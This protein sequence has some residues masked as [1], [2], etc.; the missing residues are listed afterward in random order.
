MTGENTTAILH[1]FDNG[2]YIECKDLDIGKFIPS[3]DGNA[4]ME[5][6][7]DIDDL[8]NPNTTFFLTEE[9]GKLA[10]KLSSEK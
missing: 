4:L 1:F 9:G 3:G 6:I 2:L 10:E 7:N 8:T 5:V